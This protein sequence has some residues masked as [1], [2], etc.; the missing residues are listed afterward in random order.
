MSMSLVGPT[1]T[2]TASTT[3]TVSS[4]SEFG[5]RLTAYIT[6]FLKHTL[7]PAVTIPDFAGT[8]SAPD[9]WEGNC[10]DNAA[11]C[12]FGYTTDDDTLGDGTAD[13]FTVAAGACTTAPCYAGFVKTASAPGE[14]VADSISDVT[15]DATVISYKTSVD[16]DQ[17]SGAYETTIIYIIT[18]QF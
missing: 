10:V 3:A 9:N 7:S 11:F 1:W 8:N 12:G 15:S 14:L 18:P 2:D 13:R 16:V 5:Y 6:D 17:Q 4:R